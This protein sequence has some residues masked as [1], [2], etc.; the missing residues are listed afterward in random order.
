MTNEVDALV[1]ARQ[2]LKKHWGY[3]DF[4]PA[5]IEI[6]PD[7]LAEKDVLCIMPT[8]GGKSVLFQV[9]ALLD[10]G[11]TLV[12]SP[13]IALMKDQV[14]DCLRR[15]ISA[16]YVN[17]HVDPDEAEQRFDEWIRGAY[18]LFYIA[19]ERIR[20]Q[21]FKK[22]LQRAN[23][24][25][26]AV[27]E[28]HCAAQWGHDFRPAY[29]RIHEVVDAVEKAN[30]KHLPILAVT[31][32]ATWEIEGQIAS[33]IGLRDGYTRYV[34]D[35]LRP[36]L[37]YE[38]LDRG[39]AWTSFRQTMT[40][41]AGVEG[42]H[43]VYAGTRNGANELAE[44]AKDAVGQDVGVYHAGVDQG[45]RKEIQD[46]FKDG[47]LR[48]VVATSA[49]GM[50]IDVPDIR[51]VVHFGIPDSLESYTQQAGR[52][53]RDNKPARCLLLYDEKAV[54][55]QQ[56]FLDGLNPPYAAFEALWRWLGS[57]LSDDVDVMR[58]SGK[59]MAEELQRVSG[60]RE[61]P[62][63]QITT[64]LNTMEAHGLIERNYAAEATPIDVYVA[65]LRTSHK[66]AKH[67]SAK[68]VIAALGRKLDLKPGDPRTLVSGFIDKKELA[69]SAHVSVTVVNT[70]LKRLHESGSVVLGE[71][72]VGKTTRIKLYGEK[73]EAHLPREGVEYKRTRARARLDQMVAYSKTR[74]VKQRHDLV[75]AYFLGT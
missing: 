65:E 25:R 3:D 18:K 48:F 24:A 5:Q 39:S 14:D 38:V 40:E 56:F 7:I 53:G 45:P 64:V 37:S 21:S 46:Q 27:D 36:N 62:E 34:A 75:R 69:T 72:F 19:P 6:L 73:L 20:V 9:P 66:Q 22:A 61:F 47:R 32:T 41:L 29:A 10:R 33:A 60:R 43:V 54:D 71:T 1:E 63:N 8:G 35:P 44:I 59:S 50:G 52:A 70:I 12:I 13:L 11:S 17:S 74:S 68:A 67:E 42:R 2:V 26:L 15:G 49:F 31:A 28:A 51:T 16:S 55:L 4:R 23:V 30:G 58:L 57:E